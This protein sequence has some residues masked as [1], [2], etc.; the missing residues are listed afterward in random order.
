LGQFLCQLPIAARANDWFFGH[1]GNAGKQ[2]IRALRSAIEAGFEEHGFATNELVGDNSILKAR[3]N[4]KGPGGLPWFDNR[5]LQ[6]SPEKL[7]A[8]YAAELGVHHIVQ[9]HQPS[10]VKF[11]GGQKRNKED[12][13]QRYGLLF[14]VDTGMSRGIESSKRTGGVLRITG[15]NTQQAVAICVNGQEKTL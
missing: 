4:K 2:S 12:M 9:G 3:L 14:L 8:K 1:A 11:P 5:K 7:L 13:F 15:N 6:T 10:T